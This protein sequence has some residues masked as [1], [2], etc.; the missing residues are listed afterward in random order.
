MG[1]LIPDSFIE[2]LLGRIDIVEIIERRVPL[3]KAGREFQACCPFHDEKT[4]SF[5]VSPQKQFYH[6]FGCGAHGSA[7]GFMM[8][9]EGLE[10]VDAVEELA[11]H[12]GLQVPREASSRPRPSAG[13]YELLDK[14]AVFYQQQLKDNSEAV[15]Y[16]KQ[17]GLSGEV[18][19]D[20]GIGYAPPGWDGLIGKLGT[21]EKRLDHLRKAGM[22]SKGR[23]GEYDKFRHRIMFPI[24]DRRGRVIA[25]GGRALGD[26]GPKYL[27]SPETE[28]FHKGREL[29]GLYLARRSEAKL[30]RILVVEGYMDVVALAQFGLRNCVATLGTA[31]TGDHAELLFRAADEVIFCFDGDRAGRQAAWRALENTLPRL[32]DGR[33][34]RFLFLPEGEDPD[35]MVRQEGAEAF[36]R[37]LDAAQPLSDYFFEHFTAEVDMA[38]LDGRAR[39]VAKARP[40]LDVIPDGVFRDMMFE[41]LGTLAQHRLR[42]RASVTSARGARQTT[43]RPALQRTPMRVALAHLV[44]DPSLAGSAAHD[45][46][47][48][49]QGCTLKGFEI[50]LELVD[51]CSKSP[52]MTT[53]QLLELLHDHPARSHLEKLATWQLPGDDEQRAREFRDAVT[54]LEL[55]WTEARIA[56]MPKI[57]DLG[58]EQKSELLALQNRRQELI[59][60]LQGEE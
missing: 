17:R 59:G 45:H 51:F 29:Y 26:D 8:N 44:Q 36:N 42:S 47:E 60:R 13:L 27:N 46:D 41:R 28:L 52:N 20:F 23:S 57:V 1:G 43:G 30:E 58:P 4:P 14:A 16:L 55:Q 21:D 34:A 38:A 48:A 54:G 18:A 11:R 40:A 32:K 2:E 5:T 49:L 9:Y 24:H 35:S 37:R 33:Q 7:I 22:I 50:W 53:A 6:C 56:E 12:A 3:K 10:F 31:T 15:A 25:F 39:L 19:K